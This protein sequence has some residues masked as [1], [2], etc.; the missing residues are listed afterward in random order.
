MKDD[1]RT[2]KPIL[3][4]MIP[5]L[6]AVALLCSAPAGAKGLAAAPSTEKT[7][8]SGYHQLKT[9]PIP[10][11]TFWDYLKYEPSTHRLFITHGDHVV[12]IDATSGKIVGNVG[13]MEASHG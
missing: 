13:G 4:K 5:S 9:I 2:W 11:D 1:L 3:P 10:G 8:V 6:L 12:V 7:G